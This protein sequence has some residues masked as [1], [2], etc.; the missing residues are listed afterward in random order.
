MLRIA[1]AIALGLFGAGIV[2]IVI[3]LL[4]PELS[5]RDAWSRLSAAA[6]PYRMIRIDPDGGGSALVGSVDPL[7]HAAACRFDLSDGVVQVS[8]PGNVPFWSVSVYNRGGQNIYS[9]N[10]RTAA[11]G[12]LDFVILTPTQMIELR[13]DLPEELQQSI[14]VEAPLDEGIVVVRTFVP[15]E[16][17]EEVV[18]RYL[19]T[20]SCTLG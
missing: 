9:F 15:D 6:G 14:F 3:L 18:S 12:L 17:W 16:S 11:T 20:V 10:D 13:K 1:Y 2:H 8:A 5:E 4:V 19:G 7:F